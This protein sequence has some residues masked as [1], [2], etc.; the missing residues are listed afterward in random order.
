[1]VSL[2][3]V[4]YNE[5]RRLPE[6]LASVEPLGS[7]GVLKEFV[8]L[9]NGS[10]DRTSLFAQ[11]WSTRYGV[12]HTYLFEPERRGYPDWLYDAAL[13]RVEQPWVLLLDADEVLT[14]E[15]V[16]GLSGSI[17]DREGVDGWQ[18]PR[19]TLIEAPARPGRWQVFWEWHLRLFRRH[20]AWY[21]ATG[22]HTPITPI[23]RLRVLPAVE[24][25][26]PW[27]MQV[28]GAGEQLF[29]DKLRGQYPEQPW[30][31]EGGR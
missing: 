30:P 22:P 26:Q 16:A 15:G 11:A 13:D 29:R 7:A 8:L 1:M 9:D 5:E 6:M 21:R 25:A 27:F 4:A 3:C 31:S 20:T 23:S 28:R 24:A 14:P 12:D 10:S 19:A 17:Y 2:V 18:L